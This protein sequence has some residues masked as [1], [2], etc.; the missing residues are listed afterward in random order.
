LLDDIEFFEKAQA[1][2]LHFEHEKNQLTASFKNAATTNYFKNEMN[3]SKEEETFDYGERFCSNDYY[4]SSSSPSSNY[5]S[6]IGNKRNLDYIS[7][8]SLLLDKYDDGFPKPD[9]EYNCIIKK[10]RPFKSP[11]K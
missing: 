4:S 10:S 5:N 7:S 1:L 11:K 9:V 8:S 6:E 2:R 3:K